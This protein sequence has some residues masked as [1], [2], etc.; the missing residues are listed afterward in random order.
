MPRKSAW[1]FATSLVSLQA[2]AQELA[3]PDTSTA[4]STAPGDEIVVT[5][6]RFFGSYGYHLSGADRRVARR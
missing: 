3:T 6:T 2:N 1:L 4:A 5:G